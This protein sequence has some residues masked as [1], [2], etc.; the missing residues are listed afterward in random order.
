M[1]IKYNLY[2]RKNFGIIVKYYELINC[3]INNNFKNLQK[4]FFKYMNY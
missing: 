1:I 4:I 2:I 3:T